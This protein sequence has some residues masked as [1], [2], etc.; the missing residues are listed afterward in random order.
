MGLRKAGDINMGYSLPM[1]SIPTISVR[2][3]G[4]VSSTIAHARPLDGFTLWPETLDPSQ[5]RSWLRRLLS[6]SSKSPPYIAAPTTRSA[7]S[8]VQSAGPATPSSSLIILARV[9]LALRVNNAVVDHT[10][11]SVNN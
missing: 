6:M 3:S 9:A 11:R 1:S 8:A 7:S 4:G 10:L 2:S 5:R